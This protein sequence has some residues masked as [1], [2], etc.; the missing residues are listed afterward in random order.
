MPVAG[1]VPLASEHSATR[2][3]VWGSAV[4]TTAK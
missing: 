2:A 1:E 4:L 3:R